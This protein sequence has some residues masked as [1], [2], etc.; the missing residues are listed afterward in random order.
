ML[1]AM[2][3]GAAPAGGSE[4]MPNSSNAMDWGGRWPPAN[5]DAVCRTIDGDPQTSALYGPGIVTDD[6][7]SPTRP[8]RPG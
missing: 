1:W 3:V 7:T 6:A 2:A 4:V 5:A 8:R